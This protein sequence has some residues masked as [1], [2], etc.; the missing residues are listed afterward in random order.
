MEKVPFPFPLAVAPSLN[1][2]V[3]FPEAVTFPVIL[4][5]L[6]LQTAVLVLVMVAVGRV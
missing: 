6:P 3:Q 1:V 4:V 2:I 5:L